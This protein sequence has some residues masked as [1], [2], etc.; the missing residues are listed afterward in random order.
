M[1]DWTEDQLGSLLTDTFAHHEDHV[2]PAAARLI[3]STAM[4]RRRWPVALAAAAAVA[5]A[6]AGATYVVNG[7]RSEP[8]PL[9]QRPNIDA[10]HRLAAESEATRV[11]G[12]APVPAGARRLR[13]K[14][15][16]WVG[17]GV[18]PGYSNAGLAR[19]RWFS[20]D[21]TPAQVRSFVVANQPAGFLQLGSI[22]HRV[23]KPNF[24][25]YRSAESSNPPAYTAPELLVQWSPV[26]DHTVIRVDVSIAAL[27]ARSSATLIDFR[28]TKVLVRRHR[29]YAA[30]HKNGSYL[31]STLTSPEDNQDIATLVGALNR[32]VPTPLPPPNSLCPT[33]D[34][35]ADRITF[36]GPD[37]VLTAY[38]RH[39]CMAVVTITRDGRPVPQTLDPGAFSYEIDETIDHLY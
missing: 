2:D 19:V 20:V 23:G 5:V 34:M 16:G 24:A 30:D 25:M 15:A 3:A 12:I 38:V 4:P 21:L 35:G 37:G 9:V 22:G 18:G 6:V 32:L 7:A 8:H 13:G 27:R 17:T 33:I 36:K 31:P 14:P 1:R 28:V 11:L 39:G 26:G 29:T 10:G